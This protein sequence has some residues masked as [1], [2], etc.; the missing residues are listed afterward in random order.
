MLLEVQT[1]SFLLLEDGSY[2]I[3]ED[4]NAQA[5]P[6][7]LAFENTMQEEVSKD[8]VVTVSTGTVN[9]AHMIALESE[10]FDP[11]EVDV[12]L[13]LEDGSGNI[14]LEDGSGNIIMNLILDVEIQ[15]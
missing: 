4:P 6:T 9:I 7:Y 3:L 13:Q 2:L 8:Y 5:Y 14:Q 12:D 1:K 11:T 15:L 10:I